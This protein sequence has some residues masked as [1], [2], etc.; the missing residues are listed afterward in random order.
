[1]ILGVAEDVTELKEYEFALE[2]ER[3]QLAEQTQVRKAELEQMSG[4][5]MRE[6]TARLQT[7]E[8]LRQS[9]ELYRL[10]AEHSTDMITKHNREGIVVY[11]SP[12]A[13]ELLGFEPQEL[14]GRDPDELLHPDDLGIVRETYEKIMAHPGVL[15]VSYRMRRKDGAYTWLETTS[16]MIHDR[17]SQDFENIIC[18]TRDVTARKEV[19]ARTAHLEQQLA[20][21]ARVSTLGELAAGLAHELN[22]PLTAIGNYLETCRNLLAEVEVPEPALQT[23]VEAGAEAQRAGRVIQSLRNLVRAS[24][25][26]QVLSNLNDLVVE[27]MELFA[28]HLRMGDVSLDLVL[29]RTLP[30]V[31]I[32]PVQIQQVI[33]NLIQNAL[34]SMARSDRRRVL[35]VR[36]AALGSERVELTVMDT[37][38]GVPDGNVAIL[39]EP[40]HTT[41]PTGLGLGLAICRGIV[42]AHGGIL[43]GQANPA[44]GLVFAFTLPSAG[45]PSLD[46]GEGKRP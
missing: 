43:T 17:E 44:G 24:P 20:H 30:P 23:L 39:F 7:E 34:D 26:D 25:T 38:P 1:M 14:F 31:L 11:A 13:R 3:D 22:Q 18:V 45:A 19:E 16:K 6:A 42:E 40:F 21:A 9:E 33:L 27:V 2:R 10:L 29:D 41:K 35:T 28:A 15:V 4:W 12:A 5:L 36:T 37:G 8:S 46:A 32:D